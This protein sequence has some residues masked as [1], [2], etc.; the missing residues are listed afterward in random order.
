LY[1]SEQSHDRAQAPEA[2]D[3]MDH[4]QR[5]TGMSLSDD[6]LIWRLRHNETAKHLC[7]LAADEIERLR[8]SRAKV[9]ES[10]H[11]LNAAIDEMW[12]DVHRFQHWSA[13]QQLICA[14]QQAAATA[15]AEK[16]AK[17]DGHEPE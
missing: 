4:P 9:V 6:H 11:G 7:G 2:E 17:E 3:V 8:A 13:H 10:L 5:R 16:H 1:S 12:N 15:L 14:A